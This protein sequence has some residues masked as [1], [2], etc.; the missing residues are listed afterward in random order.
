MTNGNVGQAPV[1]MLDEVLFLSGQV[2][3]G[4][5]FMWRECMLDQQ[6]ENR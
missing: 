4:N 5:R 3:F 1:R 2:F 6:S